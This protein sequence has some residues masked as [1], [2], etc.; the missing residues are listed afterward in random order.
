MRLTQEEF[1]EGLL[2]L[3]LLEMP[4]HA[5]QTLKLLH[6]TVNICRKIDQNLEAGDKHFCSDKNSVLRALLF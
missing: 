6:L 4:I 3:C 1:V 5:I 2:N